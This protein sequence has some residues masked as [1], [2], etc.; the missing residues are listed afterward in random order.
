MRDAALKAGAESL[1]KTCEKL[2]EN[3][4]APALFSKLFTL[5]VLSH[6]SHGIFHQVFLL[7]LKIRGAR[8][9]FGASCRGGQDQTQVTQIHFL[10]IL[11]HFLLQIQKH[12]PQQGFR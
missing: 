7:A 3:H 1:R 8:S 4:S 11:R 6:L 10:S 5:L 2:L 12:V 9:R